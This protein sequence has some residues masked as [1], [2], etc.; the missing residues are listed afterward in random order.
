[1]YADNGMHPNNWGTFQYW[2][3]SMDSQ[4]ISIIK[5][6][7]LTRSMTYLYSHK[8]EN[9]SSC[10]QVITAMTFNVLHLAKTIF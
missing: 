3:R 6:S 7:F 4:I 2:V 1:M 9:V 8:L 10:T 5:L